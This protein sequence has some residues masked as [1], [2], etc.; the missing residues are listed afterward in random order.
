MDDYFGQR[1]R[2]DFGSNFNLTKIDVNKN[3][4]S[5]NKPELHIESRLLIRPFVPSSFLMG[6][7]KNEALMGTFLWFF[8]PLVVFPRI[9]IVGN[10]L[11]YISGGK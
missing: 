7:L 3:F 8:G 11:R 9:M 1:G 10:L 6:S 2:N 4:I 5:K